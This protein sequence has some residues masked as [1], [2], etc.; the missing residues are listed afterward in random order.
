MTGENVHIMT[1][2]ATH[3]VAQE[4]QPPFERELVIRVVAML[5]D[6]N[7]DGDMFG[8]WV[9]SQ[10]DLGAWIQARK[11]TSHRVVTVAIDEIVF[12]K[13]VYVGDCL[14]VFATTERIGRTSITVQI[15]ALVERKESLAMEKVTEG[16]FVFVAIDEARQ[17]IPVTRRPGA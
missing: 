4:A 11:L 2:G 12:H 1:Q 3:P 15:E 5:A 13:P 7:P 16:R 9:L 6:A 17:P 10:M 8:G 14:L